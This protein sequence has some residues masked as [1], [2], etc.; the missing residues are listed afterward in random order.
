[1][2]QSANVVTTETIEDHLHWPPDGQV[3]EIDDVQLAVLGGD[4]PFHLANAEGAKAHWQKAVAE[5]P[6][7]F[8]GKMLLFNRLSLQ[9]RRVLG[10]CY[11]IPYSTFLLWRRQADP[12]LGYH[13]FA[14]AV[15]M[16]SDGALIAVEMAAHTAN[17]GLVYC[18]AGSL[19]MSDIIDG[20]V[21]VEANIRREVMEETGLSLESAKVDAQLRGYRRG[22]IVTL[23]RCFHLDM[24]AEEIFA[25]IEAHMTVDHEKEIA[26]PVAI[27]SADRSAYRFSE[28]MYPLLDWVFPG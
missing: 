2:P 1:M 10:D 17:A 9:G 6:A 16:S 11:V 14:F 26:R 8:D 15:I 28:A 22:R 19:D 23:F 13:L 24:T 5:T 21:D 25:R 27:R 20:Q 3:F 4:H 7:L 18:A 12:G